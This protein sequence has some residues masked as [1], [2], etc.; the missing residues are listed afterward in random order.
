MKYKIGDEVLVR[1]KIL[2]VDCDGVDG[3]YRAKTQNGLE[4]YIATLTDIYSL[5]PEFN[6]GEEIEVSDTGEGYWQPSTFLT[7]LGPNN[8]ARWMTRDK[9]TWVFARKIQPKESN[10][11]IS[12]GMN[13]DYSHDGIIIDGQKY[14]LTKVEE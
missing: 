13:G 1:M 5:A 6:L 14:K 2:V 11:R 4:G 8:I 7:D 3:A 10:L 9:L 12:I